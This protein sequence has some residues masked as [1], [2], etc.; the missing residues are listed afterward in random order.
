MKRI[1]NAISNIFSRV[2]NDAIPIHEQYICIAVQPL[3]YHFLIRRIFDC[4]D[5]YFYLRILFFIQLFGIAA[6]IWI[7]KSGDDKNFIDRFIYLKT[8]IFG[9]LWIMTILINL[10]LLFLAPAVA[11]LLSPFFQAETIRE[12]LEGTA[13]F[14]DIVYFPV[15]LL[16]LLYVLLIFALKKVS[17]PK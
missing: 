11:F 13:Y 4:Q 2:R 1:M 12:F 9:F 3:Y 8:I 6:A 14:S 15:V 10:I 7:N 17:R 5:F 16:S